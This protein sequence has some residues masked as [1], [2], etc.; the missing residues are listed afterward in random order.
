[1]YGVFGLWSHFMLHELM[2]HKFISPILVEY[3]LLV[4]ILI[5]SL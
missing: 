5:I 3:P 4:Y 1:M 2:H